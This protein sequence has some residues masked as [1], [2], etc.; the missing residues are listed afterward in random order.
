MVTM[1]K[2]ARDPP[3]LWSIPFTLLLVTVIVA[4]A[5]TFLPF[6]SLNVASSTWIWIASTL[7]TAIVASLVSEFIAVDNR[8][9]MVAMVAASIVFTLIYQD[10]SKAIRITVTNVIQGAVPNPLLGNVVYLATLTVV[11]GALT[12]VVL[13]G[14]FGSFPGK[15]ELK[16]NAPLSVTPTSFVEPPLTGYEKICNR[17]GRH[18]PFESS[19]CPFCGV[20]LIRRQAPAVKYCR[21]CGTCISYLGQFCPDCG[22]EIDMI[23]RS[24]IYISN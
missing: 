3:L 20:K 17:C 2:S 6:V 21:F 12:G 9:A 5:D 23:S 1:V 16:V 4:V 7:I 14:I 18:L 8:R 13:G 15:S 24:H 11:P 10:L 22:K 19:Y